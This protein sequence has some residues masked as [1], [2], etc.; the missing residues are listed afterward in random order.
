[1]F[2]EDECWRYA[3]TSVPHKRA[4]SQLIGKNLRTCSAT[5]SSMRDTC[6]DRGFAKPCGRPRWRT[7][8]LRLL[9]CQAFLIFWVGDLGWGMGW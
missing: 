4:I 3:S 6:H 1:M 9:A 5:S 7:Q 8:D 2:T